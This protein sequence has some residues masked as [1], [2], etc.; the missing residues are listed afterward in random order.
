LGTKL[1]GALYRFI[2]ADGDEAAMNLSPSWH[3]RDLLHPMMEEYQLAVLS[4]EG[5]E[6]WPRECV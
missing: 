1:E 2:E 6:P 5:A 4:Q 3:V